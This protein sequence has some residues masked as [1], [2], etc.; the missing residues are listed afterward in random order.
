ML[1]V[2]RGKKEG[3]HGIKGRRFVGGYKRVARYGGFSKGDETH[4]RRGLLG[5]SMTKQ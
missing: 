5:V 3:G 4:D 2:Q 1:F